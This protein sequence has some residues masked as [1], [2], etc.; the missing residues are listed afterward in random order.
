MKKKLFV[1]CAISGL[2]LAGA[3]AFPAQANEKAETGYDRVMRTHTLRCGYGSW[4]PGVYKD[5]QTGQM[6]GI[7]VELTETIGKYS[8]IKIDWTAEVDWGQIPQSLSA[9]K[10]DAFCSGMANDASRGKFMAFTHPWFYWPFGVMVRA[11]DTRFPPNV[12]K[13]ADLNKSGYSTAYTEGDV[14]ETIAKNEFPNVKGVP[15]PP[16]GTPADNVMNLITRKTDFLA[17]PKVF[18]QSFD[19]VNPGKLHY[20]TVDPAFRTYGS[21]I[22]VS[23]EDVRLQQLLNAG[24]DELLNSSTYR[25]IM[26]KYERNYPGA[27]LPVATAY[28]TK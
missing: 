20:L 27:F 18:F 24:V 4:D 26:D 15:L 17:L 22:A 6:K 13:L 11:D 25:Q 5:P 9:G 1:L 16:L 23:I 28:A 12:V 10:V 19:K 7:V 3:A 14:L 2:L 21:V 8:G